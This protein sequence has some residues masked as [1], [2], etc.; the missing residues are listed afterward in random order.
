MALM[1]QREVPDSYTVHNGVLSD[2]IKKTHTDAETARQATVDVQA[3][4]DA[5]RT[6]Y[7]PSPPVSLNQMRAIPD[8]YTHN[9]GVLSD[10]I[11]K[12]H[13]DAETARAAAVAKQAAADAWRNGWTDN[14]GPVTHPYGLVQHRANPDGYTFNNGV[15]A[16]SILKTH[17]DAETAR[18]A[19]VA[20]Q[21]AADQWRNGFTANSGPVINYVQ[22][23]NPANHDNY[24]TTFDTLADSLKEKSDKYTARVA[25]GNQQEEEAN[26]WRGV[27]WTPTPADLGLKAMQRSAIPDGYTFNN[28]VLSDS[29][30]K[31]HTDAETAR[32]A[33]VAAQQAADV[34]R[35]GATPNSGPVIVYAQNPEDHDNYATTAKTQMD[36]LTAW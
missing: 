31:T 27:A 16:D 11:L 19:A 18:A 28:G 10:S 4:A 35:A 1:Q 17:T 26:A 23:Q 34:W 2:S 5:W 32:A 3:A 29:I 30:K 24:K 36:A 13:T 15:L 25:W 9:N 14:T 12:T 20:A 33:A 21:K 6:G 8:G 22:R 7:T